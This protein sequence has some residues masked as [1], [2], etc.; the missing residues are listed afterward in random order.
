MENNRRKTKFPPKIGP[1]GICVIAVVA[2][3]TCAWTG[4]SH[5]RYWNCRDENNQELYHAIAADDLAKVSK[6]LA[7]GSDPNSRRV[8]YLF[9][10]PDEI[11]E[12]FETRLEDA[13]PLVY[14]IQA[15]TPEVVRVLLEYGADPNLVGENNT[16]S[17]MA[18]IGHADYQLV[19]LLLEYGADVNYRD[20]ET[21][22]TPLILAA[23]LNQL[24]NIQT[25]LEHGADPDARDSQE[26]TAFDYAR[27]FDDGKVLELLD[28]WDPSQ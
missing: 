25:I 8:C 4:W 16:P 26:Q 1:I 18:A 7:D 6:L 23:R 14:A 10:Y 13:P 17:L 28:K 11:I 27:Q 12:R 19:P 22:E 21:G 2:I 3:F 5:I 24:E 9:S 15:G 20:P